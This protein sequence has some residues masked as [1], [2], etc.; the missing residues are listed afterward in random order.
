[1]LDVIGPCSLEPCLKWRW[2]LPEAPSKSQN[3]WP[4][5]CQTKYFLC[6][7]Q[8]L[9]SLHTQ[10]DKKLNQNKSSRIIWKTLW[11]RCSTIVNFYENLS[12]TN[13]NQNGILF[14]KMFCHIC[15]FILVLATFFSLAFKIFR[16]GNCEMV[17]SRRPCFYAS[18]WKILQKKLVTLDCVLLVLFPLHP[19]VLVGNGV[20]SASQPPPPFELI[21][22]GSCN[23]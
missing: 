6:T 10:L 1:M 7:F 23:R 18:I 15:T 5:N 2:V 4:H 14:V 21:C 22:F 8:K 9:K 3:R 12:K 13:T 16:H 11:W 19:L 17:S 20:S